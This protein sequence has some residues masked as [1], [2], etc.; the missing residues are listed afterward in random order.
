MFRKNLESFFKT[1]DKDDSGQLTLKELK[2]ALRDQGYKGADKKIDV[3]Y[4][5]CCIVFYDSS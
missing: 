2:A 5:A 3:S 4:R 1:A